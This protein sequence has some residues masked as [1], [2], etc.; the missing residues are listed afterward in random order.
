MKCQHCG[1]KL[2]KGANTTYCSIHCYIIGLSSIYEQ[3]P[4]SINPLRIWC[5]NSMKAHALLCR[6]CKYRLIR[7]VGECGQ[8]FEKLPQIELKSKEV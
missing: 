3:T 5:T 8:A 4:Y 1:T 6:F 2:R 7:V